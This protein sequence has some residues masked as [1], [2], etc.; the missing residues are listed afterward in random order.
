MLESRR[1]VSFSSQLINVRRVKRRRVYHGDF[2]CQH[3]GAGWSCG[4]T[5][6]RALPDRTIYRA[7]TAGTKRFYQ[8]ELIKGDQ[9]D[10]FT[11]LYAISNLVESHEV[12]R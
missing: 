1:N 10:E 4:L 12:D 7:Y 9:G 2:Q 8:H 11:V 3:V 6:R 5:R